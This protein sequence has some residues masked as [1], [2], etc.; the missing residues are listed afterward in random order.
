MV[1]S[2][3]PSMDTVFVDSSGNRYT[4][5]PQGFGAVDTSTIKIDSVIQTVLCTASNSTSDIPYWFRNVKPYNKYYLAFTVFNLGINSG[6]FSLDLDTVNLYNNVYAGQS[7]PPFRQVHYLNDT[8]SMDS[9]LTLILTVHGGKNSAVGFT[10]ELF[11]TETRIKIEQLTNIIE[12]FQDNQLRIYPNPVQSVLKLEID[13]ALN[14]EYMIFN[15]AGKLVRS[16][17]ML[18][19]ELNVESISS[20]IYFLSIPELRL[21]KKFVKQD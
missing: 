21:N 11:K 16:G 14:Q 8:V 10:N 7:G 15:L 13:N 1:T 6:K 17:T 2:D 9:N 5:I 3:L 18:S 4:Q 12:N 20:G 19:N